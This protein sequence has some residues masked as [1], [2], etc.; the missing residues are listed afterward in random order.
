MSLLTTKSR[1]SEDKLGVYALAVITVMMQA[2]AAEWVVY[3][4]RPFGGPAQVASAVF[5]HLRG[6]RRRSP[7]EASVHTFISHEA[8]LRVR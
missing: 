1:W 7:E 2:R 4:K 8:R 6:R 5:F 3:A